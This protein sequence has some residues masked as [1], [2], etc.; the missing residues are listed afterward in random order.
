MKRR[1]IDKKLKQAGWEIT[2]GGNHD[3]ATHPQ[4]PGVK[5][6]LPRHRE[7][8]ELTAQGILEDAGLK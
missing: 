4:K 3:L 1:D 8:N 2:H 7:I 6:S 5:I